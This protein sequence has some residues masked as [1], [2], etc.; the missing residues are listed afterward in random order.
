MSNKIYVAYSPFRISFGGGGTDISPFCDMHGGAVVNT[1][2]DRGVTVKYTPDSYDLEISSRDFLKSFLI[3]K[4]NGEN[5]VLNKMSDLFQSRGITKGRLTI[6]SGVPPGSGLG[7]SSALTTAILKLIYQIQGVEVDPW[8][9]AREAFQLEHDY[10]GITLG[11]QDPFAVSLGGLK[12]MEFNADGEKSTPLSDN[13]EFLRELES[14]TL[15]VYTG[16]T[17][18]S[19][20]VLQ[21]QVDKSV[22]GEGDVVENLIRMRDLATEMKDAVLSSNFGN[23]TDALNRGWALKKLLGTKVSN[24]RID[25]MIE[26]ARNNGGEGAR[27]MGGGS[28]GFLLVLSGHDKVEALQKALMDKSS[29]VV[30]VSFDMSGTRSMEIGDSLHAI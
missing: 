3:G 13:Q 6:N 9:I 2:I 30:R 16:N 29:F 15:L 20:S 8:N 1:T 7:S 23:F 4:A 10:F 27:L 17:R 26:F 11:K 18:E 28:D 21:E 19:T 12:Y 22:R 24:D 25:S 14:R 5:D